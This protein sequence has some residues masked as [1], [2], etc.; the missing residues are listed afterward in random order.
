M[1]KEKLGRKSST[2]VQILTRMK[3]INTNWL[4]QIDF[5]INLNES[6]IK[7]YNTIEMIKK[8]RGIIGEKDFTIA[9]N[10]YLNASEN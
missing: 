4:S 7:K 8:V 5:Q 3:R 2:Q 6:E 10:L 1:W 9:T